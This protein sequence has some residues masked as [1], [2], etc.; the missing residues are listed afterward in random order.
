MKN[1]ERD[2]TEARANEYTD[3]AMQMLDHRDSVTLNMVN[4]CAAMNM[5]D[6]L[7][8]FKQKGANLP[9]DVMY[10]MALIAGNFFTLGKFIREGGEVQKKHFEFDGQGWLSANTEEKLK[11]IVMEFV[12]YAKEKGWLDG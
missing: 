7:L 12:A 1:T 11:F 10:A 6:C 5:A 8:R 9:R 2:F 4:L 3:K